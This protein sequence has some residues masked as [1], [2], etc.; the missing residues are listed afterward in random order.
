MEIYQPIYQLLQNRLNEYYKSFNK[1]PYELYEP[2]RYMFS[3]GGK[4]LRPLFTLIACDLFNENPEKAIPSALAV[5]LFHNFSLIHDDIMDKAP[6]R[7]GQT[8]V[9]EKWNTNIAILS[10]DATLVKAYKELAKAEPKHLLTLISL[11]NHT[12]LQVCEGQQYDMNYETKLNVTIADYVNM[13]TLKT[14]VLLACSL[15]MGAISAGTDNEN[16]EHLY[17]FGK[18]FGIA[19]QLKDD[20]L[21]LYGDV[22]KVGK[23]LGGDIISNKKTFLLLTALQKAK[24]NNL[25]ELKNCLDLKES[26]AQEKIDRIKAI[27]DQLQIKELTEQEIN[28]HF[29]LALSELKLVN[30]NENKKQTLIQ[31]ITQLMMREN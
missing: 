17:N 25:N 13:I 22:A 12:A 9:H 30:C 21:D 26:D 10:G 6:L 31:F 2:I 4:K 24:N 14:A 23:Q 1:E 28:T 15:K 18:H 8:A 19:F 11:L 27:Y 29:H 7:R 5:E 3:L 16:T 20:L